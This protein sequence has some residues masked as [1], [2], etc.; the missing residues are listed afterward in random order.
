MGAMTALQ[1]ALVSDV[2]GAM[3]L[4]GCNAAAEE[5]LRLTFKY[6]PMEFIIRHW[7]IGPLERQITKIMFGEAARD[8]QPEIVE[9]FLVQAR[10]HNRVDLA[11]TIHAV[12]T[13]LS[14]ISRLKEI[15]CPVLV[16]HAEQDETSGEE[17]ALALLN[18]IP[19]AI[20]ARIPRTGHLSAMEQPKLVAEKIIAFLQD[21]RL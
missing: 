6:R 8:E 17:C 18:R 9:E 15:R 11:D 12:I 19:G 20:L 7:G 16:V 4:F 21:K 1:I 13:R 5:W 2:V 3:V 10:K 14:V